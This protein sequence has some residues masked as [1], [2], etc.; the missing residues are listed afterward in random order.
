MRDFQPQGGS[1]RVVG[2]SHEPRDLRVRIVIL[3]G[4]VLSAMLLATPYALRK[5]FSE[6]RVRADRRD[7]PRS[8]LREMLGA[9]P[10]P[11]LQTHPEEDLRALKQAED[12]RLGTYGW[13]D[14]EQQVLHM[15]IERAMD[16]VIR[17]GVPVRAA[18]RSA[19]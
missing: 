12:R 9:M 6:F 14:R 5:L 13:I 8:P 19:D 18:V 4:I 17:R 7:R 10:E 11:R 1:G 16:R 2:R 3:F 15:P